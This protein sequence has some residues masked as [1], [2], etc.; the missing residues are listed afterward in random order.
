MAIISFVDNNDK[1]VKSFIERDY[2]SL[3]KEITQKKNELTHYIEENNILYGYRIFKNEP[4]TNLYGDDYYSVR[5]YFINIDTLHE[6]RQEENITKLLIHLNNVIEKTGGYYNLRIPTHI[7]DLIRSYNRVIKDAI[8]CGG[9]VEE[10][11]YKKKVDDYN[12]NQL[13]IFQADEKYINKY[14]TKLL[15]MTYQSFQTYQGQYH[16]SY[17]TDEKAGKIYKNWIETSVGS[18]SDD[19]VVVVEYDNEPIGFV[20]LGETKNAVEGILSAVSN[21]HRRYGAYKAMIAYA[22]NYAYSK[23]KSFITSTQFDNFI[24]QGTWAS[25]GLKPFYSIYNIHLDRRIKK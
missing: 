20:T 3:A 4:L 19:L 16:I 5:F 12:K 13:R 1:Y 21:E 22:I 15:E 2:S 25:L 23:D 18:N 8:F 11:I 6:R 10:Y 17:I 24:V 14:K 9:T 7:V